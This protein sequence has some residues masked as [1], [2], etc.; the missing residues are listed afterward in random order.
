MLPTSLLVQPTRPTNRQNRFLNCENG[1]N[2]QD[3]ST[4][5]SA[6]QTHEFHDPILNRKI[7]AQP[8]TTYD[9]AGLARTSCHHYSTLY[10]YSKLY[11]NMEY[12]LIGA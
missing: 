8:I 4:C 11:S 5:K 12:K 10:L 3:F 1:N 2:R 7:S 9:S 6:R